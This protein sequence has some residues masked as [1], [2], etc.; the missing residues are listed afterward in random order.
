MTRRYTSMGLWPMGG[1][2]Y[3]PETLVAEQAVLHVRVGHRSLVL[4]IHDVHRGVGNLGGESDLR[5]IG[6]QQGGEG[7][8]AVG[9]HDARKVEQGGCFH[10]H[11]AIP[12]QYVEHPVTTTTLDLRVVLPDDVLLH[13]QR[14]AVQCGVRVDAVVGVQIVTLE[15]RTPAHL[16]VV[17]PNVVGGVTLAEIGLRAQQL[18]AHRDS[19]VHG[20]G[21]GGVSRLSSHVN[22][23][24]T[25]HTTSVY[26]KPLTLGRMRGNTKT[27]QERSSIILST[28][29][30]RSTPGRMSWM[31][32]RNSLSSLY[33]AY[34]GCAGS[35]S[36]AS[37]N[38][39]RAS[40][41]DRRSAGSCSP[42]RKAPTWM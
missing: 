37:A 40:S 7:A 15:Y 1:E 22:S 31:A 9:D 25:L 38:H 5:D 41:R 28:I 2:M 36:S 11:A 29:T 13:E 12:G 4:G 8:I 10:P 42:H 16:N 23:P 27:D 20:I 33:C 14:Q 3:H 39:L 26:M 24:L 32:F 6:I 34:F 21:E 35:A 18:H 30:P 17:R 19:A